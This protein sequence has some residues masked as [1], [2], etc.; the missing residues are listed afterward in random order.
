MNPWSTDSMCNRVKNK[1]KSKILYG[2]TIK[3]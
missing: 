3:S 1:I 2:V